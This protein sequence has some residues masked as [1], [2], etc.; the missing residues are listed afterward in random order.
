MAVCA[1]VAA[2]LVVVALFAGYRIGA[3]QRPPR[4]RCPDSYWAGYRKGHAD[5]QLFALIRERNPS[6]N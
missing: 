1:A 4:P 6:R 2:V 5:G 3:V